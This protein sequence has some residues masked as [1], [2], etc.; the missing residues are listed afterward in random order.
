MG[1]D[2]IPKNK[3]LDSFSVG[4]L[5]WPMFLQE[6]GMGYILGYGTGMKP[7]SYVYQGGNNGSPSSNDG[8][9]VSS[10]EAKMMAA[11]ARGYVSVQRY[12]NKE[13]EAIPAEQLPS[14]ENAQA[15][16]YRAK[17]HE[18]HL[19]KLEKFADFAE[20]SGGFSIN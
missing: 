12:V 4:W 5:T 11:V 18:D 16:I 9:K 7:G 20:E 10:K 14:Y 15:G 1:Y 6:T 2:L 8:Y 19:V 17:I 13:W 3:K